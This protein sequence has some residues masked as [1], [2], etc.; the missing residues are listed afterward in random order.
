MVASSTNDNFNITLGWRLEIQ[1][2]MLC[3]LLSLY[4]TSIS[5]TQEHQ[6]CVGNRTRYMRPQNDGNWAFCLLILF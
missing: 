5:P 2:Y 4:E 6:I 1:A 3:L